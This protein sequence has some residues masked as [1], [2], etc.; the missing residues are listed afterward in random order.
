M[1]S[2][3]FVDVEATCWREKNEKQSEIIQIGYV[4]IYKDTV[5]EGCVNV[6]PIINPVLTDYCKDLTKITQEEVD[7]AD[8]FYHVWKKISLEIKKPCVLYSWGDYD[9]NVIKRECRDNQLHF[10]FVGHVNLKMVFAHSL[11]IG[12]CGVKSALDRVGLEFEGQQHNGLD[13]IKNSIRAIK[14]VEPDI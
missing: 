3:F 5:K 8:I 12:K 11:M 2:K 14:K 4:Y 9:F 13:D 1:L 7:K 6:K 10:P